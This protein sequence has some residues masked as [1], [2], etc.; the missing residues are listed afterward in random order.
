MLDDSIPLSLTFDDVLLL[1]RHS[2]VLPRDVDV[3]TRLA[4]N[5][6][7]GI[8]L[9][10]AAMD[11]VTESGTA[12]ALARQG[13]MGVVHKN[14]SFQRQADEIRAV[15]RAVTGTVTNPIT[16]GPS[17][18]IGHARRIMR[19]HRISGVPVVVD[20]RARAIRDVIREAAAEDV[21]LIAGKGHEAYQE[22]DGVRHAFSDLAEAEAALA[23]RRE[24]EA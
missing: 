1:P 24:G 12:I 18:T 7:L 2:R 13:G 14:M 19:Q 16:V 6:R 21:I 23:A 3:S 10:S 11:T 5:L 22:I 8:P 15:K 4:P 17:E 9:M 20:G